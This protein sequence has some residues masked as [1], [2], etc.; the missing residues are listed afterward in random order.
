MDGATCVE[1]F[2]LVC[3][4]ES[5]RYVVHY[6]GVKD[7]YFVKNNY[8]VADLKSASVGSRFS[9]CCFFTLTPNLQCSMMFLRA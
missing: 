2:E 1:M 7:G 5:C 6:D 3:P 9:P 8:L 4:L